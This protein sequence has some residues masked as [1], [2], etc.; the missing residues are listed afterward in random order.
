M[1]SFSHDNSN[2]HSW[3][4]GWHSRGFLPHFDGGPIA[5]SVTFRL[6]DSFPAERLD[7]WAEE[8]KLLSKEKMEA[9]RRRRIEDYLDRGAGE[10][11]LSRPDVAHMV[12]GAL[13][14]FDGVRY[15]LHA[16]VIMPN[17]V[18]VLLTP[19][20]EHSL[21]QVLQ[22]WKSF[23]AKKANALLNRQG[24]FW[25]GEYFDRFIRSE[26]HFEAAVSYIENNPVKAG[27]CQDPEVWRFTSAHRRTRLCLER[28]P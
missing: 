9:E 25:Q 5:Q 17:H 4:K 26:K 12:E 18:H 2:G 23:T 16:W 15:C 24:P 14:H 20:Q 6:V 27:L 10:A 3:P 21:S 11:W 28:P 7:A 19:C 22:S 8:L 1:C 13:L